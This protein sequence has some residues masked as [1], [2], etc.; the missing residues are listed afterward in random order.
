MKDKPLIIALFYHADSSNDKSMVYGT[1]DGHSILQ[2]DYWAL[3]VIAFLLHKRMPLSPCQS[4]YLDEC[5]EP[6][7]PVGKCRSGTHLER[8]KNECSRVN[9][10]IELIDRMKRL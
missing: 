9:L 1:S 2:I 7:V 5:N 3:G 10:R 8:K 6:I 4:N